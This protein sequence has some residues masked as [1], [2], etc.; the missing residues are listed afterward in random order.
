VDW[1]AANVLP[2]VETIKASGVVSLAGIARALN[3]RGMRSARGA[4]WHVSTVA[5]LLARAS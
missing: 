5:N 1:F 2:I 4:Q 3:A